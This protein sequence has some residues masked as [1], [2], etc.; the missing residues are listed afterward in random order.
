MAKKRKNPI[1]RDEWAAMKARWAESQ[2][3][4]AERIAYHEAKMEEER[5]L[6]L[7]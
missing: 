7:R 2:R 1:P 6:G 3:K 4:L 5:R